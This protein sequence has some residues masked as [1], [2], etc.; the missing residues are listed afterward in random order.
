MA[1]ALQGKFPLYKSFDTWDPEFPQQTTW[2]CPQE[3]RNKKHDFPQIYPGGRILQWH[4][5]DAHTIPT[6]PVMI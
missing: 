2:Q 3:T 4:S 1:H 5:S 6:S